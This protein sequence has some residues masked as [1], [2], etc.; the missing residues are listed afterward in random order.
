[1]VKRLTNKNNN[2]KKLKMIKQDEF[3]TTQTESPI[4]AKKNCKVL[5]KYLKMQG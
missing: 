1:M 3:K 4:C 2:N 5:R